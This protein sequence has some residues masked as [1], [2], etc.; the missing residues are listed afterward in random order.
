MK[1]SINYFFS[2]KNLSKPTEGSINTQFFGRSP[3]LLTAER[4][5]EI[6]ADGC[7]LHRKRLWYLDKQVSQQTTG[8]QVGSA[9]YSF[10]W[11]WSPPCSRSDTRSCSW[12]GP[13]DGNS[14]FS[15]SPSLEGGDTLWLW[16]RQ[17]LKLRKDHR[18]FQNWTKA[19]QRITL[20]GKK[21]TVLVVVILMLE[22]EKVM[23][24]WCLYVWEH[25][26]V[27]VG[28]GRITCAENLVYRPWILLLKERFVNWKRCY[29]SPMFCLHG[30]VHY[31]HVA[32]NQE[33][34]EVSHKSQEVE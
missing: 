4:F 16:G 9:S 17:E 5:F 22:L 2:E 27:C 6:G 15:G 7:N 3:T 14:S 24:T 29:Q 31:S 12:S 10:H 26:N 33:G 13:R 20:W 32:W 11:E 30:Y 21:V 28:G 25:L 19:D 8:H 18:I 23:G 1:V 34:A